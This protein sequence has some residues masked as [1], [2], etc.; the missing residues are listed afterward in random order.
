MTYE[1]IKE[2]KESIVIDD[3]TLTV[4]YSN[5]SLAW[6]E[7][8]LNLTLYEVRDLLFDK[9]L[10]VK[11]QVILLYAGLIKHHP[12]IKLADLQNRPQIAVLLNNLSDSIMD[13]FFVHIIPP[14]IISVIKENEAKENGKKQEAQK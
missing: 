2:Y 11:D 8:A 4:E 9:K 10:K 14:E 7:D 1:D 6:L 12:E 5:K 3:K 13:A